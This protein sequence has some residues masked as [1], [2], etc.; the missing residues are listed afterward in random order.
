MQRLSFI[1]HSSC[2]RASR[3]AV[4]L[5]GVEPPAR[6]VDIPSRI[7]TANE[8]SNDVSVIDAS[9]IRSRGKHRLEEPIHP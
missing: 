6:Q 2:W 8:S 4:R 5:R 3:S 1:F 9:D 7:Y